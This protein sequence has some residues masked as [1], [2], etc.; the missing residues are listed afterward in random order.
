MGKCSCLTCNLRG[1]LP[2]FL[3]LRLVLCV[4]YRDY[5]GGETGWHS[6]KTDVDLASDALGLWTFDTRMLRRA[7]GVALSFYNHPVNRRYRRICCSLY[8]IVSS[9]YVRA[10]QN[11]E[12][13]RRDCRE[14]GYCRLVDCC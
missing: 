7:E 8:G 12:T 2:L 10:C 4:I 5:H 1:R 14:D 11:G 3:A 9:V 6:R 13:Y